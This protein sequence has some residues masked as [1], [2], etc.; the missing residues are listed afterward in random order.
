M[1]S[2]MNRLKDR[3]LVAWTLAYL[4]GAWLLMQ[5]VEVLSGRWPLPLGLQRGIDLTLLVGLFIAVTLAWYHGEKGRQKVSGP[6]LLILSALL[7]VGGGLLAL[8]APPDS[9]REVAGH[10]IGLGDALGIAVLP[11][12]N[13][14]ADAEQEYFVSG[15]HEALISSLSRIEALRVISRT[16]V[17]RYA[18][19]ERPLPEI[20]R[21]L[22]VDAVIEGSVIS[23]G[24]RVRITVQLIDGR[25]DGHL[26]AEEYDRD[27]REVLVL[28][29]QVAQSVAEHV[30][31]VLAPQDAE[32]LQSVGPVDPQLHDLVMRGNYSLRLFNADG[33]A[34]A[35]SYFQEA[36]RIDSTFVLAWSGLAGATSLAAYFGFESAREGTA[37]AERAALRALE[38]D[39]QASGAHTALG[40]ARLWD[41]DWDEAQSA[42]ERA[43]E[44]NPN[45]VDAL[46]GF[47][48]CLTI[49]GSP[50]DGLAY[51]KR[52]RDIDPFSPMW[53]H[54]VVGHLAMMG[55]YEDAVAEATGLLEPLP[56][57][58]VRSLRA[59]ALWELGRLEDALADYRVSLT[60]R[61]ALL[62]ALELGYGTSGP[63]GAMRAV[64][65]AAAEEATASGSGALGVALWYARAG[66]AP[67]ALAWLQSAYDDRSPDLVYVGVRS[68]LAVL[69]SDAAFRA[70]LARMGLPMPESL[71]NS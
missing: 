54:T 71:G 43:L 38:L 1:P 56:N 41:F 57:S 27:L 32:L 66:D 52:A 2:P 51:V 5:L 58:P 39:D 33:V 3:K 47:G 10:P 62:R 24:D 23:V 70:L 34:Q 40:W 49:T 6:E 7:F 15:M 16:S 65:A 4:A 55:R 30:E 69:W 9:S 8:F 25:T 21:E 42:F 36:I 59:A 68:E 64:A 31:V 44:L 11:L 46:H 29:S 60:R 17:M 14:S 53:G 22:G 35:I 48:D 63:T 45:D 37:E 12:S 61:P 28:M 67:N 18:N 13:L 19:A 50:D 20:A 26:W